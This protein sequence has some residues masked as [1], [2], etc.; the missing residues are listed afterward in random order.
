VQEKYLHVL[1]LNK[2]VTLK[3][4]GEEKCAVTA[5]DANHCP[6][7]VILLFSGTF[8]TIVHTGDFRVNENIISTLSKLKQVDRIYLDNTFL[9]R[10]CGAYDLLLEDEA[11]DEIEHIV[12]RHSKD[13]VVIVAV[14]QVGKEELLIKLARRYNCQVYLPPARWATLSVLGLK[15]EEMDFFTSDITTTRFRVCSRN[16]M[17]LK[18][19]DQEM[20]NFPNTIGIRPSGFAVSDHSDI[21]AQSSGP[22]EHS[23]IPY[24]YRVKYSS[25]SSR[26]ELMDFLRLVMPNSITATSVTNPSAI[27]E[28]RA[29]MIDIYGSEKNIPFNHNFSTFS[30]S[31]S[32]SSS[33]SLNFQTR[34]RIRVPP[35]SVKQLK[36]PK[37]CIINN[38]KQLKKT[39]IS[40]KLK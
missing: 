39:N 4:S 2:T 9:D 34:K 22:S 32:S 30:S 37:L 40:R 5:I 11:V 13:T 36:K 17:T 14:A 7:S 35:R 25:H 10:K 28:I 16:N 6:G 31:S 12:S 27:Q 15:P 8:G 23:S 18:M 21:L 26:N 1:T 3:Y 38:E 24:I 19:I 29:A 20:K 33:S